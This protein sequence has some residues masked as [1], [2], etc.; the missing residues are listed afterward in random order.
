MNHRPAFVV[1][2][3]VEPAVEQGAGFFLGEFQQVA[4]SNQVGDAEVRH[5]CLA[6]SEEFARSAE[7]EIHFGNGKAIAGFDHLVETLLAFIG[8]LLTGHQD[9]E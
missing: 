6:S 5:T 3:D 1:A 2:G 8:D 7:L 9:A 4:I